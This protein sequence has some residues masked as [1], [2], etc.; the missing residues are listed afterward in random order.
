MT[1]R[2]TPEQLDRLD[3]AFTQI[4]AER[5]P[6]LRDHFKATF[7]H[8]SVYEATQ[9]Q[10]KTLLIGRKG[11]GKTALLYGHQ[12]HRS[13]SY[14]RTV[15]ITLDDMPFA[16]LF[17]FFYGD[18]QKAIQRLTRKAEVSDYVEIEKITN[19]AWRNAILAVATLNAASAIAS[20]SQF[21]DD[22]H[23]LAQRIWKKLNKQIE[24]VDE[25]VKIGNTTVFALLY[26]FLSSVQTAIDE[27][28][29]IS[30]PSSVSAIVSKVVTDILS[31]LEKQFSDDLA[32]DALEI[33]KVLS[34]HELKVFIGVD[35]F[36][37]YYDKF[38]EN[39]ASGIDRENHARDRRRFLSALLEGLVL[40]GREIK[41][42]SA[43]SWVDALF[44]IPM[45]KFLELH[46]R[47]R[48]DL[49]RSRVIFVQ[50]QP[51]E[52]R[53]FA[54]NRLREALSLPAETSNSEAWRQMFPDWIHN[55]ATSTPEESFLYFARH[56]LWKP[57]ELLIHIGRVI[58]RIRKNDG[59]TLQENELRESIRSSCRE[60]VRQE[61][62]EEFI[63][64]YP[65]LDSL[66]N[67]L[68]HA[69][70]DTVMPYTEVCD[71]ISNEQLSDDVKSPAEIML[72]LF[73]MG[74]VGVRLVRARAEFD[75]GPTVSQNRLHILYKFHFNSR[76][77]NPFAHRSTVVF[78]PMFVDVIGAVHKEDYI[79]NELKWS[80][81]TTT[82]E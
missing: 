74:V 77:V 6:Y 16:A 46:L 75:E 52:L 67:T 70:I 58:D 12:T 1:R 80:M 68:E 57:R 11:S 64:E 51:S 50:W 48:A 28:I 39:I 61:F 26:F 30:T 55:G 49:E 45:D 63:A 79:I 66:L 35:K 19:F 7:V 32:E 34:K 56:S 78:H 81:W 25:S 60:I 37:D 27:A 47:E 72:R 59:L 24:G 10:G 44:A 41:N 69:H 36:D 4:K 71:I 42:A 18:Y 8:T 23:F 9:A 40:T 73:K 21:S 20:E 65:G 3:E 29:S 62:R 76:E 53:A 14:L 2:L 43:F 82:D 22:E 38:Y 17:N 31:K 13:D 33:G 54:A 15:D 5:D